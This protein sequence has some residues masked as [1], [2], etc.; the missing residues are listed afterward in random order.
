MTTFL[1]VL[2]PVVAVVATGLL[3]TRFGVDSRF[4]DPGDPRRSWH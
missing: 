4:S 2:L 1:I 3:A